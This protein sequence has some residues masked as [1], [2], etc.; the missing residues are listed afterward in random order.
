MVDLARKNG[1][2]Q[3]LCKRLPA[4]A[5]GFKSVVSSIRSLS[6]EDLILKIPENPGLRYTQKPQIK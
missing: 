3:Q 4:Q 1:D 6:L 5:I 2:F